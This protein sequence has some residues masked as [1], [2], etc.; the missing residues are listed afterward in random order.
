MK[1]D[2]D[3][4]FD[5]ARILEERGWTRGKLED[6][7]GR[8]CLLGALDRAG[9]FEFAARRRVRETLTRKLGGV[10]PERWND[11]HARDAQEVIDL[12]QEVGKELLGEDAV[13]TRAP[14]RA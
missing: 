14:S 13:C 7:D 1:S 12:L 9:I 11:W 8:H 3:I 5:A 10:H 6:A 4:C 2:A